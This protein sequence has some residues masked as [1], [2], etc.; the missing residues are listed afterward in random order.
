MRQNVAVAA[1]NLDDVTLSDTDRVSLWLM[2][3]D[4]RRA[5]QRTLRD[6]K[7]PTAFDADLI[8]QV[9]HA[10]D[11]MT[12]KA[13]PIESVAAWTTRTLRLRGI[14]LVR[15]PRS[16]VASMVLHRNDGDVQIDLAEP[17]E[18]LAEMDAHLDAAAVRQ[19]LGAAWCTDEPWKLSAALTVLTV[20]Y[21][22]AG[23]GSG[24]PQP[25]GGASEVEAAHWVG[26]W[27]AGKRDLFPAP[28]E[29]A[30]NTLTKRR[31]RATQMVKEVL[32]GSA[33][34]IEGGDQQ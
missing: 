16:S 29:P 3:A 28:G 26:L 4:G 19:N 20:L 34:T 8:T 2:S 12:A 24:C 5:L 23:P 14:D 30:G 25:V 13:Q 7:L 11:Q 31:S 18:V 32:R 22:E 27:Y 21:D 10:A 17:T 9:C 1:D 6:L 15:S 33:T